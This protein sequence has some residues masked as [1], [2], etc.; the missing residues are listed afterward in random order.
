EQEE[1]ERELQEEES[2]EE[3][4]DVKDSEGIFAK[5]F[6]WPVQQLASR[7]RVVEE[8]VG[9][10]IQ[11]YQELSSGTSFPVLQPPIGVDSTY[12]GWSPCVDDAIYRLLVPLKPGLGHAF[13]MEE[14]IL[15]ERPKRSFWI[16]VRGKCTCRR[17]EPVPC[18]FH[19]L[20]E[21]RR[22][23][24]RSHQLGILCTSSYLDVQ[25]TVS[26][27]QNFVRSV[28]GVRPKMRRYDL[29]MLPSTRSCK[30]QLTD[31]LGR[32]FVIDLIFGLQQG[33]SDIFLCSC[34]REATLTTNLTSPIGVD[35]AEVKLFWHITRQVPHGSWHLK[36]LHI[37]T[38]ILSGTS[39]SASALKMVV[40][41]LLITTPLLGWCSRDFVLL[42]DIMQY[43]RCCL[44]NK[45]LSHFFIGNESIPEEISL[46]PGYEMAEPLNLFHGLTQ[47]PAA[48]TKAL[49][50]FEVY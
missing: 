32:T 47:D 42:E 39:F 20:Q 8:L 43:L 6:Q 9:Q 12:E 1:K 27:F 2:G 14:R 23:R 17:E 46:P 24:R 10:L 22:R 5:S 40:M 7:R 3:L 37:C 25:K 26:W 29:K 15:E 44:E 45:H 36:G 31:I 48:Y 33:D 34:S 13:Y 19:H 21:R 11:V 30:L 35:M 41:H 18:F 4:E 16:R 49:S 50:E 38:Q 28:W